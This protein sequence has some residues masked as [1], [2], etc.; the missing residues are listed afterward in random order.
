M[1]LIGDPPMDPVV[2]ESS[3]VSRL[4]K[5]C[6]SKSDP[7]EKPFEPSK[8]CV[9]NRTKPERRWNYKGIVQLSQ[10]PIER[11]KVEAG[12]SRHG[13]FVRNPD[14]EV[15]APPLQIFGQSSHAIIGDDFHLL[16]LFILG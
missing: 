15:P 10:I 13:R 9:R 5:A 3:E 14:S 6:R 4:R 12:H 2:A 11:R 8:L 1:G 16:G 7:K